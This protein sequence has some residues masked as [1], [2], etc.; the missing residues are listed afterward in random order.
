MRQSKGFKQNIC[1]C[2]YTLIYQLV[3]NCQQIFLRQSVK[4]LDIMDIAILSFLFFYSEVISRFV[5]AEKD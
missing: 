1:T 5:L 2:N 4:Y 3:K